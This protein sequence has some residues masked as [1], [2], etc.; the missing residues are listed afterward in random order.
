MNGRGLD[1]AQQVRAIG[2]MLEHHLQLQIQPRF[3]AT[4]RNNRGSGWRD[5]D[6]AGSRSLGALQVEGIAWLSDRVAEVWRFL[7]AHDPPQE[8][9]AAH[10][11]GAVALPS[12]I[13]QAW[14]DSANQGW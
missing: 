13:R 9:F 8:T 14:L 10:A 2:P 6:R 5:V 11:F 4:K 7:S 12:R 3:N 1:E